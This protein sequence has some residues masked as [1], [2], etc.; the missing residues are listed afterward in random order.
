MAHMPP[1][2]LM[3]ATGPSPGATSRN[4]VEKLAMAPLPKLARP[5][6]L[7]PTMRMPAARARAVI[8]S[9]RARP[10]SPVSEKPAEMTMAAATPSAAH[11]STARN[12]C[13]PATATIARSGAAG[14]A[15]RLGQARSPW[16][17]ARCGLI[18]YSVPA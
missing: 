12:A 4:M 16:T 6:E 10:A 17:S 5:C 8:A 15:A 7:G 2:W 3:T 11:S 9:C 14:N 18:G 1:L 13:S